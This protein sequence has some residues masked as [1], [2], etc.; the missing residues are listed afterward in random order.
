MRLFSL[1]KL[2]NNLS[3]I[4]NNLCDLTFDH[5]RLEK[6][7]SR[8]SLQFD[9]H[10]PECVH[11]PECEKAWGWWRAKY[12]DLIYINK[13]LQFY[14]LPQYVWSSWFKIQNSIS[15]WNCR[16]NFALSS[17]PYPNICCIRLSRRSTSLHIDEKLYIQIYI[18]IYSIFF[19]HIYIQ[20]NICS[21]DW[22]DAT[23]VPT[24]NDNN[25]ILIW[26]I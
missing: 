3:A 6:L 25:D 14:T 26:Q 4:I 24:E 7:F 5:S 12:N 17:S 10:H 1:Y 16:F 21:S 2:S 20:P 18:Q 9:S 15:Q 22:A 11:L 19:I 8:T 23:P 13:K